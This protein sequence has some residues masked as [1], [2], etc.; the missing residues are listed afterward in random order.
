MIELFG[1]LL[2][3]AAIVAVIVLAAYLVGGYWESRE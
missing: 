1:E 2:A 3:G